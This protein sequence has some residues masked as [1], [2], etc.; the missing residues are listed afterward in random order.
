M[1]L[2]ICLP[3]FN[4][5]KMVIN[6][7]QFFQNEILG[8]ENKIE[9]IVSDNCSNNNSKHELANFRQ[10]NTFFELYFQEKN[11]GLIGNS[12]FLLEKANSEYIWFVGDDDVLDKGIISK[13]FEIFNNHNDITYVFFNHDCFKNDVSNVIDK[14]DLTEFNGY[15]KSFGDKMLKLLNS[16]GTIN[17]FMTSNIYKRN[18]LIDGYR[19]YNRN[20]QI[21]DFLLFSNICSSEGATFVVNKVYVHDN[22]TDSSWSNNARQIFS[23]SLP[24]RIIDIDK[25]KLSKNDVVKSLFIFYFKGRGNF[26]YMLLFSK[27]KNRFKIINYLGL[28]K[29]IILFFNSILLSTIRLLKTLINKIR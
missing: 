12:M 10:E 24:E 21:D 13:T 20:P 18:V 22:Y 6:Q 19:K 9:I 29:S 23:S 26:L 17:M 3:T 27:S 2:S 16:Y 14:F 28:K 1:K 25:L 4:R 5:S 15:H 11:L 8:F 7:L